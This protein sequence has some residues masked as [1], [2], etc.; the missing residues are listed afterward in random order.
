VVLTSESLD[1]RHGAEDLVDC[2]ED[3]R[4]SVV[5]GSAA[6]CHQPGQPAVWLFSA[7]AEVV[8]DLGCQ[9]KQAQFAR[10]A[11]VGTGRITTVGGASSAPARPDG[12]DTGPAPARSRYFWGLRLRLACTLQ[13]LPVA[14]ALAGA[15]ADEREVLAGMLTA[16]PDL[17]TARPSQALTGDMNYFGAA[18][19]AAM[20][21]GGIRLLRPARKGGAARAGAHLFKPLRQVIESII[22]TFKGQPGLEQHGGRTSGGVIVRFLRRILAL[23]TAIWHNDTTGQPVLRSLVAYDHCCATRRRCAVRRWESKEV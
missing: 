7:P 21:D 15:E 5:W 18:F 14:F 20:A 19:G 3:P 4:K 1:F 13:G 9:C 8:R 10:V 2:R 22:G 12:P 16:G 23:T 17:V 6:E 11:V